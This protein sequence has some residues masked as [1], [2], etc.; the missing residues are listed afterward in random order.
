[1][2]QGDSL[3]SSWKVCSVSLKTKSAHAVSPQLTMLMKKNYK[4][5]QLDALIPQPPTQIPAKVWKLK[6][7]KAATW[8]LKCQAV[9]RS[10]LP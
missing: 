2:S 7:E 5:P 10:S 8:I 3:F 1:M 4:E 9:V 6:S